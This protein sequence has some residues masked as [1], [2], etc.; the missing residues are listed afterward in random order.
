MT[1]YIR[2]DVSEQEAATLEVFDLIRSNVEVMRS[3]NIDPK[4][5]VIILGLAENINHFDTLVEL[6]LIKEG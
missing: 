1:D 3:R 5:I 4:K 2:H 6:T